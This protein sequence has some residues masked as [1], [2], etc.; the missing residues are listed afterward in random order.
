MSVMSVPEL[1]DRDVIPWKPHDPHQITLPS[2]SPD[3][4]LSGEL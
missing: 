3:G 1:H 2:G 4:T